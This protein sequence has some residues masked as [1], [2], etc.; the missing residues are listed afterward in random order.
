VTRANSAGVT[1]REHDADARKIDQLGGKVNFLA[2]PEQAPLQPVR[3][4]LGDDSSASA[5]GI[6]ARSSSPIL[7]LCRSL[8][9]AG[10]DP[11]I[12]LQAYRGDTLALSV[13]SIGIGARLTI[14]SAGN[15][16]PIFTVEVAPTRCSSLA[17]SFKRDPAKV[18]A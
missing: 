8:V 16:A 11:A 12:P 3:A 2:T 13:V 1:H 5:H 10:L 15:G 6:I 14:K 9:A 17:G 4:E 7:D 18:N